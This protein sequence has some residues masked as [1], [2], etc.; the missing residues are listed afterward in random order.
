MSINGITHFDDLA[1]RFQA[2]VTNAVDGIVTI[3]EKGI[4][5]SIN[6]AALQFFGYEIEELLGV[7]VK[8]LMFEPENSLYDKLIE[9]H[10]EAAEIKII[11]KGH[12]VI[13]R[14]KDGTTFPFLLSLSEV[15][16]DNKKIFIGVIHDISE[17][18]EVKAALIKEKE[19]SELKSRFVTMA[20]HEFRTPLSAILSSISLIA[21]YNEN[22]DIDKR[23]KHVNRIRSSVENLTTILNGFLSLS[24]LEEGVVLVESVSFDINDL[25]EDL[26]DELN[27]ILKHGQKINYIHSGALKSVVLDKNLLRNIMLNLVS[28]GIKYSKEGKIIE[29]STTIENNVLVLIVKDEGIGI[30]IYEQKYIFSRFFRAQNVTNISGTGLGLNIVKKYLDLL[31]GTIEFSSNHQGT[32]FTVQIPL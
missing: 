29:I 14:R 9:K 13:G 32:V 3:N 5:E 7:N 2:I 25:I 16:H 22:E 31:N 28:N 6:P 18:K 20:S 27:G 23:M 17:L 21:R 10:P 11:S 26:I 19:L 8:I 12:E 30:P 1:S 24:R 15:I 4:I